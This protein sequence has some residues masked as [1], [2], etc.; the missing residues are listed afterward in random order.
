MPLFWLSRPWSETSASRSAAQRSGPVAVY[1]SADYL[2]ADSD[3][4]RCFGGSVSLGGTKCT[5]Q[6][7][8][9]RA[10]PGRGG[11]VERGRAE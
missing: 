2:A 8:P 11:E 9:G 5:Q 10:G 3:E 1:L 7:I 4:M 6:V